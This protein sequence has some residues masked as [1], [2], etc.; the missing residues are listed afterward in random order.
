MPNL[1]I[2][3]QSLLV[4]PPQAVEPGNRLAPKR[5]DPKRR[6]HNPAVWMGDFQ[7]EHYIRFQEV[8]RRFS[9]LHWRIAAFRRSQRRARHSIFSS[10]S[11]SDDD[12]SSGDAHALLG[13]C[14]QRA[15]RFSRGCSK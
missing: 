5:G 13:I 7:W 14:P 2:E 11:G 6:L 9:S 12:G 1:T 15:K 3:Q 4:L 8:V 10:S